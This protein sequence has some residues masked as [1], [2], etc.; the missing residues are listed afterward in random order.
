MD[1]TNTLFPEGNR[2]FTIVASVWLVSIAIIMIM[3][4]ALLFCAGTI[5]EQHYAIE[6]DY[7]SFWF[8]L[9]GKLFDVAFNLCR[10]FVVFLAV[11][12][13]FDVR[14]AIRKHYEDSG[15]L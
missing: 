14:Y 10:I 8:S 1:I 13:I 6:F 11:S 4:P 9:S 15:Y 3:I 12:F 7:N 5:V 2:W